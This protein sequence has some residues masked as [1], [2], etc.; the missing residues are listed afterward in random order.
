MGELCLGSGFT[1][2]RAGDEPQDLGEVEQHD[3]RIQLVGA[4]VTGSGPAVNGLSGY[5]ET[6][7]NGAGLEKLRSGIGRV[8]RVFFGCLHHEDDQ[9]RSVAPC[10]PDHDPIK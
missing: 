10:H 4:E 9:R 5:V 6:R 7:S 8:C 3:A 2:A 1:D